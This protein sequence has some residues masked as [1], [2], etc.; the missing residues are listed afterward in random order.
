MGN[1]YADAATIGVAIRAKMQ[2]ERVTSWVDLGRLLG[3]PGQTA[4]RWAEDDM[5]PKKARY[6]LAL[7]RWLELTAPEWEVLAM[8][9]RRLFA[10]QELSGTP[11]AESYASWLQGRRLSDADER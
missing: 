3:V 6:V 2:D 1:D 8:R 11:D 4:Q 9:S 10:L 5:E 7:A